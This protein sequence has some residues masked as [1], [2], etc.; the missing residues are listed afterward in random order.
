MQDLERS[1]ISTSVCYNTIQYNTTC[2]FNV[3]SKADS[4]IYLTGLNLPHGYSVRPIMMLIIIKSRQT[5]AGALPQSHSSPS[6]TIPLPQSAGD[7]SSWT[8][9]GVLRRHMSTPLSSDTAS[10]SVEH[11]D[12]CVAAGSLRSRRRS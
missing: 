10:W 3:R 6:S 1:I 4:L 5:E 12:H 9:A 11:C 8:A 7:E 2:Y